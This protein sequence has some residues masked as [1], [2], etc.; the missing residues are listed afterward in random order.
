MC[1][2]AAESTHASLLHGVQA[3]SVFNIIRC[4]ALIVA[5]LLCLWSLQVVLVVLYIDEL[6]NC[7]MK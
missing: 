7:V 5:E 6:K 2:T 4:H 3:L 1:H